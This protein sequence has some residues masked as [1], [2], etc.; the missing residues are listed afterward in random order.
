M[1]PRAVIEKPEKVGITHDTAARLIGI[2]PSE[3]SDLVRDGYVHRNDKNSYS[4][5]VLVG[6]YCAHLRAEMLR[7]ETH[8]KQAETAAHCDLSERSIREWEVKLDLQAK[9]YTRTE[10]RIAYIRSLRDT[11]AGRATAGDLDLATERARLAAAQA[12]KVEMQNAQSREELAPVVYLTEV[13]AKAGARAAAILEAIPGQVRRRLPSLPATEIQAIQQEIAKAR[14]LCAAVS[15]ADLDAGDESSIPASEP[16][17]ET[18][19][20]EK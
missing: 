15:L 17:S 4:V 3:L 11:A 7:P 1:V 8:P 16:E 19:Q 6:E 9:P 2:T 13:L 10:F 14:N 5:P 18:A 12:D 20:D